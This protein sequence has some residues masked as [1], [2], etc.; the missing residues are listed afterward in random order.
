MTWLVELANGTLGPGNTL[1]LLVTSAAAQ[2]LT[3]APVTF[4]ATSGGHLLANT[5]DGVASVEVTVRTGS[6]GIATVYV[7]DGTN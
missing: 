4:T 7:K 6:D 3:N 2:P 1:S 5:S